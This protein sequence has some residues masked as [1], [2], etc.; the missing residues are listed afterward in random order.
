MTTTTFQRARKPE[1]IS[2]RRETLLAAAAELFDAEGPLGTGLNAIAARA[3]FTKSNVYRYFESREE[4][5]L[6]LFLA[7][8]ERLVPALAAAV[9]A[10]PAGDLDAL[11]RNLTEEFI[12]RPRFAHLASILSSTLEANVSEDTIVMVK[13]TMGGMTAEM[14]AALRTRLPQA[15]TEDAVWALSMVGALVTGLWP[16]AHPAPAAERVLSRPEFAAHRPNLERDL[17]R[18]VRAILASIA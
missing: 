17:P 3:G 11:A 7:E 9:A 16:G 10:T 2:A 5:L 14:A 13:R 18:A 15:S 8:M 4:V 6:S 12:S 1:E